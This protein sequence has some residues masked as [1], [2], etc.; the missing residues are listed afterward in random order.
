MKQYPRFPEDWKDAKQTL[1][2]QFHLVSVPDIEYLIHLVKENISDR[3]N[4]GILRARLLGILYS[5]FHRANARFWEQHRHPKTYWLILFWRNVR[6]KYYRIFNTRTFQKGVFMS[7]LANE[8]LDELL[9]KEK[10]SM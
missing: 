1:Y 9:A 7:N 6:E 4:D 3:G 8:V 5:Y 2:R 10:T